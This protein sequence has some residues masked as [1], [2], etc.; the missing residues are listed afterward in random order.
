MMFL[1]YLWHPEGLLVRI[2]PSE[3]EE[4]KKVTLTCSTNCS[5]PPNPTYIWYHKG[6]ALDRTESQQNYMVLNRVRLN[7]A[8][9]YSCAVNDDRGPGP[10]ETLIV[11]SK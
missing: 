11:R 1:F 5:L 9:E 10:P 8:G 7:D 3:V 4:G 6:Q 2:T